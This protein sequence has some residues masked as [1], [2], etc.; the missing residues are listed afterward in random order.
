MIEHGHF[1]TCDSGPM[2]SLANIAKF[3]AKHPLTCDRKLQAYARFIRWQVKGRL[4]DEIVVPWVEGTKLAVRHGMAGA[5]GNIYCGLHEF[6]DMAFALHFLRSED[7]FIDIGANIGS[8]TVLASGVRGAKTIAFEPDPSAFAALQRNLALNEL[9][10]VVTA[11]QCA[12]GS[13]DGVVQFTIGLDTMNHV[14]RNA[15]ERTRN[16][17]VETLDNALAGT[18]PNL[19]KLDVEGFE[20]EVVGGAENVLSNPKLRAIITEDS[21]YP[22]TAMLTKC[23]FAKFYYDP[24]TRRLSRRQNQYQSHN[25]LFLR[26][27]DAVQRTLIEAKPFQVLDKRF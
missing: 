18:S 1:A 5:T 15:T 6:Q 23:G 21:S 20:S 11:R 19:I 4:R 8:Y 10:S 2:S 22:V 24:F 17:T 16:V 13:C 27:H 14:S 9:S 7:L 12:L 3:I 25:T 26:E